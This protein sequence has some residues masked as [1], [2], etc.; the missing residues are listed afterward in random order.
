LSSKIGI[1]K[2]VNIFVMILSDTTIKAQLKTGEIVIEP[3]KPDQL[4]PCSYDVRLGD[5]MMYFDN[6][7]ARVID[8]EQ[9]NTALMRKVKVTPKKPFVLHPG[10]FALAATAEVIGVSEKYVC[11]LNGKSSLGRL[12]LIIHATAGFIDAGNQLRIT[13]ELFNVANLPIILRP[14]M[15][16]GQVV[17]EEL[18][19]PSERP[20]GSKG[21]NSKYYKSMGVE[22]SKMHKNY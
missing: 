21:L 6:T 5:E 8:P 3:F 17:F 16:I 22:P 2:F 20:Y 14:G 18:S 13:L 4:Q 15:K 7:T 10:Q 12:G 11:I 19:Q 9:D 1:F